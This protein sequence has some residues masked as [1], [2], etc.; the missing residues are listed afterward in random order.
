MT[1]K[2]NVS[3]SVFDKRDNGTGIWILRGSAENHKRYNVFKK[4]HS[5][6]TAIEIVELAGGIYYGDC[7]YSNTNDAHRIHTNATV[8]FRGET[9]SG[10]SFTTRRTSTSEFRTYFDGDDSIW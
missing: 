10:E 9:P 8:S 6:R 7:K 2:R 1:Y 3:V 5:T 4:T